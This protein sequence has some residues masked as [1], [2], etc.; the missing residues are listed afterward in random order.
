MNIKFKA[1]ASECGFCFWTDESW[2]PKNEIIDWSTNYDKEFERYSEELVRWVVM[3]CESN[4]LAQQ[5]GNLKQN[6]TTKT[7]Q[8]F[9]LAKKI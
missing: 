7:L 1:L 9:G 2:R 3:C 5:S 8:D 4:Q 6:W